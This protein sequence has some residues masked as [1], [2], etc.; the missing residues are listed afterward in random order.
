MGDHCIGMLHTNRYIDQH[1]VIVVYMSI[2]IDVSVYFH[3]KNGV[4]VVECS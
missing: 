4:S 3:Y 1:T 2:S